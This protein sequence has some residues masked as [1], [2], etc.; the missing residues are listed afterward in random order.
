[1]A[2]QQI[3]FGINLITQ[4]K[5]I[6]KR[7]LQELVRNLKVK[8]PAMRP[9][10]ETAVRGLIG[11]YIKLSPEYLSFAGGQLQQELGVLNPY[12]PLNDMIS[13]LANSVVVTMKP[14]YQ[15]SGQVGGG[16]T[17][18]AVPS[19]IYSQLEGMGQYTSKN[20]FTIPWLQ[21]LLTAGDKIIIK[22]YKVSFGGR[23]KK[24]SRTGPI[25]RKSSDGWGIGASSSRISPE[26]SGTLS[27]NF[28]TRAMDRMQPELEK[29][30]EA[31][32]RSKL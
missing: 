28:V 5:T 3:I 30:F 1:M 17:V 13:I 12:G 31:I 29:K 19:T 23:A 6:K 2:D 32:V 16:F 11:K 9:K 10:V 18:T 20:G 4:T 25:M 26:Y 8:I 27:N 14:V 24:L 21:W 7:I 15:R 22:D